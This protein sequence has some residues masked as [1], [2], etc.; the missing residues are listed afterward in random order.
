MNLKK[1]KKG[2]MLEFGFI[3]INPELVISFFSE[4][5]SKNTEI[6]GQKLST[7]KEN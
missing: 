2:G 4:S 1:K 6:T 5:Q 7:K 3:F